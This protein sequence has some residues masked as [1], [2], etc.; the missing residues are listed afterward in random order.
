MSQ[1][2]IVAFRARRRFQRAQYSSFDAVGA[3]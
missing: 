3:A 1:R 2:L